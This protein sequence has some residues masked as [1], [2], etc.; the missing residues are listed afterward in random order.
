[1]MRPDTD[2]S[3]EVL[4]LRRRVAELEAASLE[5]IKNHGEAMRELRIELQSARNEAEELR[6][7]KE[8]YEMQVRRAGRLRLLI[9]TKLKQVKAAY[10]QSGNS[11]SGE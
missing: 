3:A 6:D 4:E 7:Y 1:M 10:S 2:P 5:I 8:M 9:D 11:N